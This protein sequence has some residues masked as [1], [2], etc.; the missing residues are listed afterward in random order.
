MTPE[1][2]VQNAIMSYI[3]TLAKQGHPCYVERRQAGGFSYKMGI[4]DLYAIYA[5][6]HI[7]IEVKRPGGELR[8]MQLKQKEKFEKIGAL[9]VCAESVEDVRKLFLENFN[10]C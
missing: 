4:P 3:N 10:N 7:E 1:K 8:S 9:Y 5:G 6:R 2:R